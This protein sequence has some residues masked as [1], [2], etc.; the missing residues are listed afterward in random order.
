[1]RRSLLFALVAALIVSGFVL[2]QTS[3]GHIHGVARDGNGRPIAGVQIVLSG[4]TSFHRETLTGET[5]EFWFRDIG[6]GPY[7][8][9]ASLT[10]FLPAKV[11]TV[12]ASGFTR[13]ITIALMS[14]PGKH[15]AAL[16]PAPP[17]PPNPAA[18]RQHDSALMQSAA[19]AG[20][21]GGIVGGV[22]GRPGFNTEAYDKIDDNQW[23]EV[24]RQPLST[25]STDVDTASYANVRRFLNQGQLPPK[26]AVRIEELIN[27][28]CTNILN[29]PRTSPSRSRQPS[30]TARGIR[31]IG[32]R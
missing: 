25:F 8:I 29:L 31:S 20:V 23:K 3:F 27:Y 12:V 21:A 14:A 9:A 13:E 2:A 17:A 10:G 4:G 32:L 1:M 30:P 11:S 28:F 7:S 16:A 18:V 26:D 19:V 5:G 6:A 22:K 15:V 24:S